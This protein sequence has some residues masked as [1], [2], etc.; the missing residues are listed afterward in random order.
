MRIDD[1]GV[2]VA[3]RTGGPTRLAVAFVV[4]QSTR[5]DRIRTLAR[6]LLLAAGLLFAA[7]YLIVA[8]ARIRYPFELEWMEGGM[9]DHVRRILAGQ[10][11]YVKPSLD[12]VSYLYMP[13]YY[14]ASAAMAR[15]IGVGFLPLRLVSLLSSFAV[16]ALLFLLVQRE[17]G[18]I[19]AGVL[20]ACL[21]AATYDR[22][23]RWFDLARL[24]SFYLLL[25]LATV[26]TLRFVPHVHGAAAA[27]LFT[28]AAYL[29]KQSALVACV[30]LAVACAIVDVKRAL[31]YAGVAALI[32]A[33][34]TV[35]IDRM[36][37]GW[38]SYYCF[39]IPIHH[40][41]VTGAWKDFWPTDMLRP[42][43]GACLIAAAYVPVS[44][45]R[46]ANSRDRLLH[47]FFGMG[48]I[49]SSWAVRTEVGAEVNN[50][51]PAYAGVSILAGI[52]LG[53]M[54]ALASQSPAAWSLAALAAELLLL[55]QFGRLRYDP[56]RLIP[57][58]GDRA[59]GAAVVEQIAAVPGEVF[60]PHHGYLARLA[61][62]R[63]FAHTLAMD[64]VFLDDAGSTKRDL[65]QEMSQAIAGRRFAAVLL[66]S[67]RR[68]ADRITAEYP[69]CRRLFDR[70]D[71]FWPVAGAGLR[72]EWLCVPRR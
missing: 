18:S 58:S 39:V 2:G 37:S 54:H 55:A 30:P 5:I 3:R 19:A 33:A 70:T 64:N 1:G 15:I 34:S 17:T 71:V 23:G 36:T 46:H 35:L 50:L 53:D 49:A 63:G 41:H 43:G 24:D 16:F 57:T 4:A 6:Y 67:D 29:T 62:K 7:M 51:F 69:Q 60:V 9:V 13:L 14:V 32:V 31:W 48:L 12:F 65:E 40:P 66:E 22:T 68:Y 47:A 52:V 72:P 38:F 45:V 11:I 27:G 21:F 20:A 44:I 28:G 8:L 25:L 59:A 26:F 56:R 10:P 42:F 61:G